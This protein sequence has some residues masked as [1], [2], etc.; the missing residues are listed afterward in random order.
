MGG[1]DYTEF[2]NTYG[3]VTEEIL[4]GDAH[5][6]FIMFTLGASSGEIYYERWSEAK[7]L[8]SADR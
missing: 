5:Y 6:D 4:P 8:V 2:M 1:E 3:V 7:C